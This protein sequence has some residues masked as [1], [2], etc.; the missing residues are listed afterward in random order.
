[1][2]FGIG[3]QSAGSGWYYQR[4]QVRFSSNWTNAN[5]PVVK[6]CEPQTE[7]DG[8]ISGTKENHVIAA[9]DNGVSTSSYLTV[10]LQGPYYQSRDLMEQPIGNPAANLTNGNWHTMEVLFGPEST[11]GAG[12]GTYEAWVDN[13][14]VASYRNVQW[15]AAGNRVGWPYLLFDP[16]YGGMQSSPPTTMYWDVDGLYVSTR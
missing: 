12:N 7:Q 10:V 11:P 4:M 14:Q 8:P 2:R 1:V 13:T 3:V 9:F 5:N 16:V 15:L 6:L